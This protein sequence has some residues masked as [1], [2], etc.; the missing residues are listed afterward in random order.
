MD[1]ALVW[2]KGLVL[3][4]QEGGRTGVDIDSLSGSQRTDE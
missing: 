1:L 3:Q 2:K 4:T